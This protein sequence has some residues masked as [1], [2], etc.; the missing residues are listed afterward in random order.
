LLGK[1]ADT[2]NELDMDFTNN[3]GGIITSN[4]EE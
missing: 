3:V 2:I 1:M 4:A